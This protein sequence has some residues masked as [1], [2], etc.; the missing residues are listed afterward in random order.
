MYGP[1]G[2]PSLHSAHSPAHEMHC[3]PSL[4]HLVLHHGNGLY[5]T[6]LR[7][8]T[9]HWMQCQTQLPDGTE[10]KGAQLIKVGCN[11]S[12][13]RGTYRQIGPQ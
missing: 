7:W 10:A 5:R 13:D 4:L 12:E 11:E 8:D 3:I 2:L 6:G 1:L 9:L